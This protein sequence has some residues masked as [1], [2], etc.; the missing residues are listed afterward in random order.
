[1]RALTGS[2]MSLTMIYAQHGT[3]Y[4]YTPNSVTK[5]INNNQINTHQIPCEQTKARGVHD[6]PLVCQLGT[7][8]EA[9]RLRV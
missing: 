6:D 3:V 1:V 7:A 9:P 2:V 4:A 5:S 8:E